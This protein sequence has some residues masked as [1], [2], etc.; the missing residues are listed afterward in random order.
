MKTNQLF[1]IINLL[2]IISFNQ[3]VKAQNI[4]VVQ[5]DIHIA[6]GTSLC[7][8]GGMTAEGLA[9]INNNGKM[10]VSDNPAVGNENWT[11]NASNSMLSGTGTVV[12]N[13]SG[14]QN[15]S[16]NYSTTFSIL[17]ISN[18]SA[19]GVVLD[20]NVYVSDTLKLI[21][22]LITTGTDTIIVTSTE[23]GSI[24]DYNQGTTTPSFI[25]GNLR[26]YIT[27]NTDVYAFPVGFDTGTDT[28]YYLSE[29]ENNNLAGTSY[30]DAHFGALTNHINSD[31]NVIE[32]GNGYYDFSTEGVWFLTPDVQPAVGGDCNIRTYIGNFFGLTDN[33][34]AILKRPDNSITAADWNCWDCG[35]GNSLN[36]DGGL[37]RMATDAYALRKNLT[38][39]SQFGIGKFIFNV[40]ADAGPDTSI[41]NGSSVQIGGSPTASNGS[42]NYSYAWS[43]SAGL[44][45]TDIANPFASPSSTTEYFVTVTDTDN[46]FTSID[47]VTVT[48]NPIYFYTENQGICNGETYTWHGNDYTTV[49]TY[50][51][52]LLTT[53]SCDSIYELNLTVNPNPVADAGQDTSVCGGTYINLTAT[54]GTFYLWST[55]EVTATITVSP[56]TTTT[57]TVTVTDNNNCTDIDSVVVTVFPAPPADA[58]SD[59][60]ICNGDSTD[61]TA[62]G[63]VSYLWS[64]TEITA[65]ITVNP[66]ITTTYIVTVTGNNG[67]TASDNVVVNVMPL[68]DATISQ[69]GPFCL[70]DAPVNLTA[71]NMGG[72]WSG[73]GITDGING[74]FNPSVAAQG[75]HTIIYTISGM[76]GDS[77]T[78]DI[79]VN[80][81][82]NISLEATDE[83]CSGAN[84]G[85]IDLTVNGG[86]LPYLFNWNNGETT[87]D[88]FDLV[89][90]PYI[91]I[92]TDSNGCS[93]TDNIDILGSSILCY[94]PNIYIPNIFSPN[95][96]KQNDVLYVR[97]KGIKEFVFVIYDRWG[98]EIFKTK[99]QDKGWDGT[100]KG[101]KLN[102]SV[103]T[104]Y[105]YAVMINDEIIKKKGA[106]TLIR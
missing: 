41:C 70:N 46:S 73:T 59:V 21:D 86:T 58:G 15:I 69:A 53:N 93:V 27:T 101:K 28:I 78:I 55:T 94:E 61:L 33:K 106:I 14:Q 64:T 63:G 1:L 4:L 42:G 99:D 47:S 50:Y 6:S 32:S 20:T 57:Y 52:S 88:I 71:A 35:I 39:F 51:D 79:L 89:P 29:I 96:D 19:P 56:A 18:T 87:E 65:T 13:S 105:I 22:G 77:D 48:V 16:G 31:L 102:T 17:N 36:I 75:I 3:L 23:A 104:Y 7:I 34:F 45:F 67:C 38:T 97:G 90:A 44:D 26:R 9:F 80:T 49:G 91:I 43:P 60:D 66:S 85:S 8:Q 11:N 54:G 24:T 40:V 98:E 82:P 81:V 68:S 103:F 83:S 2:L 37:G 92:V 95:G 25:N 30:L 62:S 12:F 74:T 100:Y 10:Y 84:D 72:T 5:A 76:C